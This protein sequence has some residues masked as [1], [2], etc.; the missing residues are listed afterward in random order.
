MDVSVS[1]VDYAGD[2]LDLGNQWRLQFSGAIVYLT[3]AV[4]GMY[5]VVI[6]Y[7]QV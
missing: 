3:T 2:L 7:S 4:W 1:S 6:V 5:L